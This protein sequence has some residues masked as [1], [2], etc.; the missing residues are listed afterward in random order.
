MKTILLYVLIPVLFILLIVK[1][2]I[3]AISWEEEQ[4]PSEQKP[5][6]TILQWEEKQLKQFDLENRLGVRYTLGG[7][8]IETLEIERRETVRTT[9]LLRV[10]I[11]KEKT[12]RIGA[13]SDCLLALT[14]TIKNQSND[15]IELSEKIGE[16]ET[17]GKTV[18]VMH[19]QHPLAGSYRAGE[20]R[21]GIM[22]IPTNQ[23]QVTAG[24]LDLRYKTMSGE[25]QLRISLHQ[26][27]N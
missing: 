11:S 2:V 8:E 5:A 18:P 9:P 15:P 20:E 4:R 10:A 26:P 3:P 22:F 12:V 23:K 25:K 6:Q 27:K 13:A 14:V 16:Y 1:W 24:H 21:T 7:L 17:G 19:E